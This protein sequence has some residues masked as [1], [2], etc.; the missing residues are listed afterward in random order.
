MPRRAVEDDGPWHVQGAALGLDLAI[1]ALA[2]R[3]THTAPP[4][5]PPAID[6]GEHDAFATSVALITPLALRNEDLGAI[7]EAVDRGRRR[8]DALTGGDGDVNALAREIS[9]DG[10]RLRAA[11][12]HRHAPGASARCFR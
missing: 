10:W 1:P 12:E 2:L 6:A 4:A 7:A 3:R 5:R 8:V 9:M 11:L